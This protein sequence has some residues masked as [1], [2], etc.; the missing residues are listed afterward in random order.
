MRRKSI[1][2]KNETV[3]PVSCKSSTFLVNPEYKCIWGLRTSGNNPK[4]RY[5][6]N[7]PSRPKPGQSTSRRKL[8]PY[9]TVEKKSILGMWEI[10]RKNLVGSTPN[11]VP[12]LWGR[13]EDTESRGWKTVVTCVTYTVINLPFNPI[14]LF[15]WTPTTHVTNPLVP[16]P[17]GRVPASPGYRLRWGLVKTWKTY[18]NSSSQ[19]DVSFPLDVVRERSDVEG[20]VS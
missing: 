11:P 4:G 3:T 14:F 16:G 15:R 1:G 20:C 7:L 12:Q 10:P 9:S 17:T 19:D 5:V 18:V 6:M 13:G 8:T 2:E